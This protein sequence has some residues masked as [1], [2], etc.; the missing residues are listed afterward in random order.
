MKM[1]VIAVASAAVITLAAVAIPKQVEADDW[2]DT[3][4]G[5]LAAGAFIS[6]AYRPYNYNPRPNYGP[7]SQSYNGSR[8]RQ[9]DGSQY[10]EQKHPYGPPYKNWTE[11]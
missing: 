11:F 1:K 10:N 6:N 4:I 9:Y 2:W 8:R 3:V 5:G 7:Y